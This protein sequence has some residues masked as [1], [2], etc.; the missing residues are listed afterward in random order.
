V[1]PSLF[2]SLQ[3]SWSANPTFSYLLSAIYVAAPSSAQFSLA[4]YGYD[5]DTIVRA[6]WYEDVAE[7]WRD[8]VSR[9]EEL[10]Q[11]T[12]DNVTGCGKEN[13]GVV[14]KGGGR[15]VDGVVLVW[16]LVFLG[17]IGGVGLL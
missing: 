7:V 12:F 9:Q 4:V 13:R 10:L 8:V 3:S 16:M 14:R 2:S 15:G 6:P 17:W 5:W 1:I 11:D